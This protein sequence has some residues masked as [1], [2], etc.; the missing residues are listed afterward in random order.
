ML[1]NAITTHDELR[2][3]VSTA[4]L[5][6]TRFPVCH[7]SKLRTTLPSLLRI[8]L[9]EYLPATNYGTTATVNLLTED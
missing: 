7:H 1:W 2:F 4:H 6:P 8:V 5:P 3:D 9:N